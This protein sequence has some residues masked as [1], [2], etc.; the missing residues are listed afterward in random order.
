MIRF[1]RVRLIGVAL[2]PVTLLACGSDGADDMAG[3]DG[4]ASSEA[5]VDPATTGS[6]AGAGI[7]V[8]GVGFATPESVL[9]DT[10]SD[11][12]L[13]SNINGAPTAMDGNGFISRLSP[14][15]EVLELKWID[16]ETDGVTL[17]GPKGMAIADGMLWVSDIDCV[18]MFDLTSGVAAGEV[19][20]DGATFL[21]DLVTHP[22]GPGV[23]LTDSGLDAQFSPTGVD[24]LYHV[25]A[26]GYAAV[27]SD[28]EFGAPNGVT[29]SFDGTAI[30]VTFMSGQAYSV[31]GLDEKT[32]ILAVDGGQ[33]D[34]VEVL[35]DGRM[36]VSNWATSC[37]HLVDTDGTVTCVMPDLESPADIGFD[38]SRRHV[39][40]PLFNANEVRII[41]LG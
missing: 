24:A 36:L 11:V 31:T 19:C 35:A 10:S 40:V 7:T 20:V 23:L 25:T 26:D 39:L 37:V 29:T 33:L 30:V 3:D 15:G 8:A 41:P 5:A 32:E 13:V 38:A 18:R 1:A 27:V 28:P 17:N 4:E 14:E 34:G 16:G 12:Y 21:N 9:H 2:L 6:G 22:D